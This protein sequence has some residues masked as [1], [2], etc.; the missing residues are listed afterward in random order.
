MNVFKAVKEF[1]DKFHQSRMTVEEVVETPFLGENLITFRLNLLNEEVNELNEEFIK[2]T[3]EEEDGF[4]TLIYDDV[5]LEDIN[6]EN[7][8]KELS[9]ILYVVVGMAETFHLPLE[10]VFTRT[11][12]SNMTKDGGVR[13]DGKILKGDGYEPPVM[14]DLFG[15]LN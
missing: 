11:H 8:T 3:I 14:E 2:A 12:L 5:P 4:G 7:V 13:E 9:D 1:V 15:P 6:W 10:E